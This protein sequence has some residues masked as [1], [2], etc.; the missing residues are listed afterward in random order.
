MAWLKRLIVKK[1]GLLNHK[2]SQFLARNF[3]CFV[4]KKAKSLSKTA[5]WPNQITFIVLTKNASAI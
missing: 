2:A 4:R 5:K 3:G 1:P